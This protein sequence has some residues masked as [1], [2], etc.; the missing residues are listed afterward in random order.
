MCSATVAS[1]P[2]PY[3]SMAAISAASVSRGG[4]AVALCGARTGVKG[5][6]FRV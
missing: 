1:V 6:G 4:A 3:R 5:L 2:M